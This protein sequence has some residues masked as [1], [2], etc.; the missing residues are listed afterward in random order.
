MSIPVSSEERIARA[1]FIS[2]IFTGIASFFLTVNFFFILTLLQMAGRLQVLVQLFMFTQSS[3][4]LVI[5]D[6]LNQNVAAVDL[7]NEAMVRLYV[8]NRHMLIPD[9]QEMTR[10][11][12]V[13]GELYFLSSWPL[14]IQFVPDLKEK[15]ATVTAAVDVDIHRVSRIGP[16]WQVE[17]DMIAGGRRIPY[18]ATLRLENYPERA[19][20]SYGFNNPLGA[21]IVD[22]S[23]YP[24]E[25]KTK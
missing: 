3:E 20:Y 2:W 18:I 23:F 14:Y 12:G 22:Y 8:T 21:T 13:G 4:E 5:P 7:L 16:N 19:V 24:V 1:R 9:P 17:F 25:K 11:W 6:V 10:R 15:V